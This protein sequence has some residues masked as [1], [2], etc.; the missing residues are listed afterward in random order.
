MKLVFI[1]GAP[2]TGKYTVGRELATLTGL[3]LYH[4]H[5]VVDNVLTRHPFGSESFVAERDREWRDYFQKAARE[6]RDGLIFTFNP[7]NSV[8]QDFIDWLFIDLPKQGVA[9]LSVCLHADEATIEQRLDSPQR[10]GFRKL[11]DLDLYRR[12]R[13]SDVFLTPVIPRTDLKVN[14]SKSTP[15]ETARRIAGHFKLG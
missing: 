2:A 15:A 12:L 6:G 10:R 3:E 11:T 14:T 4:N 8:P 7:E 9:I 5:L 1:H 13:D